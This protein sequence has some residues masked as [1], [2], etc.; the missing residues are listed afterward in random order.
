ISK[1]KQ[2][3][4]LPNGT[5]RVL[6]EGLMRAEIQDY[7]ENEQYY[8]VIVKE[9]HEQSEQ[10]PQVDALMRAVLTQFENYVSLSK[11]VT[12]ET[13]AA[14]SDIEEAGRL[15]DVITSHLSLKIKDKQK[16]LETVDVE[17]R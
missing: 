10:S 5:I 16:I 11:K 2:M 9:L 12:P 4:K 15:A 7:V 8:E 13:Y 1:V 14:V 6:A 3:L 17:Q